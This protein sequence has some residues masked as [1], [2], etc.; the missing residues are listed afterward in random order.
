MYQDSVRQPFVRVIHKNNYY[1]SPSH[2][3]S[4][5]SL[6]RAMVFT[7]LLYKGVL[8]SFQSMGYN[9]MCLCPAGTIA[10]CVFVE[11]TLFLIAM[12]IHIVSHAVDF[13]QFNGN[14]RCR[15]LVPFFDLILIGA[16]LEMMWEFGRYDL[17]N[18]IFGAKDMQ[19]AESRTCNN[20]NLGENTRHSTSSDDS[21]ENRAGT[22]VSSVDTAQES[23]RI[24][25]YMYWFQESI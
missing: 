20:G 18:E 15:F 16:V 11:V 10:L 4:C 6:W 17:L 3:S 9:V 22:E 7:S 21:G 5:F 1:T 23:P 25:A 24:Y 2:S 14:F 12:F 13:V 8:W 19:R